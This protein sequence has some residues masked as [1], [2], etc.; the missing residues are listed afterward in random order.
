MR[1]FPPWCPVSTVRMRV[2]LSL[3]YYLPHISG[4]TVYNHRLAKALVERGHKV[5]VITSRFDPKLPD[6]ETIEGVRVV[7]VPVWFWISKGAIMPGFPWR[8]RELLRKHDAAV[9]NLPNTP[10]EAVFGPLIAR[11][12]GKP[13][14]AKHMC[15][16]ELPPS[17]WNRIVNTVTRTTNLIAVRLAD[18]AVTM[19]RDYA[20]H[21]PVLKHAMDKLSV[22]PPPVD[23]RAVGLAE[24]AAWKKRHD[25]PEGPL[26]GFAARLSTEKGVEVMLRALPRVMKSFPGATVLFAGERETVIGE[27]A[28]RERLEPMLRRTRDNWRFLGLVSQADLPAF[29]TACDLTVLPSLNRTE[30]FGIVQVESMLCGTPVVASNLP[31]V[32][33]AI[34]RTGMGRIV[35]IGDDKALGEAIIEVLRDRPKHVRPAEEIGRRYSTARTR[36]LYERLIGDCRDVRDTAWTH[37]RAK[38]LFLALQRTIEH[39]VLRRAGTLERPVLDI[40]TGDGHFGS[41]AFPGGIDVGL[42]QDAAS[43]RATGQRRAYRAALQGSATTLPL[44]SHSMSTVVSN[45]TLE[46]IPALDEALAEAFRVLRPGGRFI[47]TMPTDRWND[48]LLTARALR[49]IGL[50]GLA[51]RY[52]E[53]FRRI[54]RHH[55]LLSPAAWQERFRAAGFEIVE[56]HE[57]CSGAATGFIELLHYEGCHN[58]LAWRLTGR[59]VLLPWRPLSLLQEWFIAR[60]LRKEGPG[61]NC[62]VYIEARKPPA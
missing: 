42:D 30:S 11:V 28:Y 13:L 40:G 49:G 16:I 25:I 51:D 17:P 32:R 50:H 62:C 23:M 56:A 22:I 37:L 44:A 47:A 1:A 60:L 21:S 43:I 8:F 53:W 48:N 61:E 58:V 15:D 19:T 34:R 36:R 3:T 9:M 52:V 18:R 4:I 6:A 2:L 45:S 33:D 31:G 12:A 20:R 57:Y 38:P 27:A 46:H 10:L 14:L 35:P 29:Y 39:R 7:R 26:I 55:H 59:W 24:L 41:V 5:T 54:Q